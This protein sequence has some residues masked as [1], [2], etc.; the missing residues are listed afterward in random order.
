LLIEFAGAL[1][2][3]GSSVTEPLIILQ[4]TGFIVLAFICGWVINAN[5]C[6]AL[7][8]LAVLAV[9]LIIL[10]VD[11]WLFSSRVW[12]PLERFQLSGEQVDEQIEG[13]LLKTTEDHF[14]ILTE[15]S[16]RSYLVD[17]EAVTARTLCRSVSVCSDPVS[18]R[19][20]QQN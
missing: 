7:L 2:R 5:R 8:F 18:P 15:Y 20:V 19:D 3:Y 17:K 1:F 14:M 16:R 13:Y 12:L 6:Q 9:I 10:P 11:P 4:N